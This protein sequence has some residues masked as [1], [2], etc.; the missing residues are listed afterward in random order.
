MTGAGSLNCVEV[1]AVGGK[2][3]NGTRVVVVR[4]VVAFVDEVIQVE[5]ILVLSG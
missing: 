3:L 1:L 4:C 5:G 2:V